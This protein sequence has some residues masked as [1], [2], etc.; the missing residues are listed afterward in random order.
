[1]RKTQQFPR[2]VIADLVHETSQ[3]AQLRRQHANVTGEIGPMAIVGQGLERPRVADIGAAV[4]VIG[5]V[6]ARYSKLR[7]NDLV[8]IVSSAG[9][10]AEWYRRRWTP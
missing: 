3:H 1:M 8:K 4:V 7:F 10:R 5:F 2:T 6:E 9:L